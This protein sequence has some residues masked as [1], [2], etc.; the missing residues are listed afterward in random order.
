M[1]LQNSTVISR[2]GEAR[3]SP[4]QQLSDMIRPRVHQNSKG[5]GTFAISNRRENSALNE[6]ANLASLIRRRAPERQRPTRLDAGHEAP[7][8]VASVQIRTIERANG[9]ATATIWPAVEDGP[10]LK[11]ES[12]PVM[13]SNSDT[14]LHRAPEFAKDKSR[15]QLTVRMENA[16][17]TQLDQ[18][19]KTTGRTYQDI[20]AKAIDRYL[21]EL[22]TNV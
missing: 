6:N 21:D 17:F 7:V 8:A 5:I 14:T 1:K 18:I 19:A 12:P 22:A 4:A 15:R 11:A 10:A 9:L 20:L 3:S 13:T 2:R 16:R